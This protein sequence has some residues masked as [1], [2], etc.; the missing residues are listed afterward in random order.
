MTSRGGGTSNEVVNKFPYNGFLYAKV[1]EFHRLHADGGSGGSIWETHFF[2]TRPGNFISDGFKDLDASLVT[3]VAN[4]IMS[5]V[6]DSGDQ[7]TCDARE[8]KIAGLDSRFSKWLVSDTGG[9]PYDG[10]DASWGMPQ[11]WYWN[12]FRIF[13]FLLQQQYTH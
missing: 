8:R 12:G 6:C 10:K 9:P 4:T 11:P 2:G 1:D 13:F 3:P 5:M 7:C